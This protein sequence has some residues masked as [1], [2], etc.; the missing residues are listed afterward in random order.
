MVTCVQNLSGRKLKSKLFL[1]MV[2]CRKDGV[3]QAT[4]SVIGRVIQHH[5]GET[6]VVVSIDPKSRRVMT[7][8][9]AVYELGIPAFGFSPNHPG[10][11]AEVGFL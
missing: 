4:P 2:D 7:Q 9:R 11:L 8:D 1:W 10:L 6:D 3:L 5:A